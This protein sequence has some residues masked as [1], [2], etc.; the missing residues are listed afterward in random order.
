MIGASLSGSNGQILEEEL[1]VDHR[2]GIDDADRVAVGHRILARARGDIAGTAGAVVDDQRLTEALVQFFA[3]HA[4]EDVADAAGA[5][6]GEHVDRLARVIVG[7][8]W[9]D[10]SATRMRGHQSCKA[11]PLFSPSASSCHGVMPG[12]RRLRRPAERM[13]WM[14]GTS[15]AMTENVLPRRA[16]V[17]LQ[18][19]LH[20]AACL[21][22]VHLPGKLAAQHADDLAHVLHAGGAGFLHRR[23]DRRLHFVI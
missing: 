11:S 1:V 18:P 17:L 16:D 7:A 20:H 13:T 9:C 3:K 10:A 5:R 8:G 21:G 2:I 14:A 23:L 6:G 15:P 12:I 22:H 4:H 19:R